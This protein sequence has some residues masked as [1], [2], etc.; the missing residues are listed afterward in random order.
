[1]DATDNCTVGGPH[2]AHSNSYRIH[3]VSVVEMQQHLKEALDEEAS[4]IADLRKNQIEAQKQLA[5][6]QQKQDKTAMAQA[7][8]R[9][10]RSAKRPNL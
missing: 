4:A 1:V 9:S 8:E 2:T 6:A 3:V 5:Q 7:Q 10:A